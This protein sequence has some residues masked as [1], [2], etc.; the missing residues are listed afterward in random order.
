MASS[1]LL[2]SRGGAWNAL[3]SL[4]NLACG[5]DCAC[6]SLEH[7]ALRACACGPGHDRK[8]HPVLGMTLNCPQ[9]QSSYKSGL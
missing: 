3:V 2:L 1:E 9:Q 6:V 5:V 7:G 4:P 8:L